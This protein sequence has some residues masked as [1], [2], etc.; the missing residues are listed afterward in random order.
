MDPMG[1]SIPQTFRVQREM[2]LSHSTPWTAGP[3]VDWMA[4]VTRDA[5]LTLSIREHPRPSSPRGSA[6]RSHT[7]TIP[8]GKYEH[9]RKVVG[10]CGFPQG[11]D[12]DFIEMEKGAIMIHDGMDI[13]QA[14]ALWNVSKN[15]NCIPKNRWLRLVIPSGNTVTVSGCLD[16]KKKRRHQM[17][18]NVPSG[19]VK[20]AMENGHLYL[21]FPLKMVDLSI[22]M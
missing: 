5:C 1:M 8:T 14:M 6:Q 3:H 2:G 18:P 17:I 11:F 16:I 22:V 4:V 10:T 7:I 13:H 19:Y 20:I 15:I 9:H 12:G 21:I